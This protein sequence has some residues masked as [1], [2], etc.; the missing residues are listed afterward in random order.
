MLQKALEEQLRRNIQALEETLP[1]LKEAAKIVELD[2]SI[3]RLTRMDAMQAQ[4]IHKNTYLKAKMRCEHLKHS[5]KRIHEESFG[6][7]HE[8]EEPIGAKRLLAIPESPFCIRCAQ[9]ND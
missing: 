9:L 1:K 3:G 7:C 2:S 6:L 5:L 8:C 4:A